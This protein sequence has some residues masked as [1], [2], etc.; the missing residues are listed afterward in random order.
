[1]S[2]A[3]LELEMA[4]WAVAEGRAT[5]EE[6]ALV[7]TDPARS[8]RVLTL[9]ASQTE[10]DLE[11]ARRRG[12]REG[13]LATVDLEEQL[14]MLARALGRLDGTRLP[15]EAIAEEPPAPLQLQASWSAGS[16]VVWAAGRG[17]EPADN[18]ELAD[19]LESIGGPALGWGQHPDVELP[20]GDRADALRIPVK[21]ALGWLV[22]VGAGLGA[23][24][25]V[26]PSVRW[27]GHVAT[28]A[29][30][31]VAMGAV[32]PTLRRKRRRDRPD[33]VRRAMGAGAPGQR[34][35]RSRSS[36]PCRRPWPPWPR[37]TPAPSRWPRSGPSSTPSCATPPPGS[38]CRPRRPTSRRP[39][40]SPRRSP[41]GW[42]APP[43][44]RPSEVANEVTGRLE[45]WA[46]PATRL[47]RP[48]LVVQ[49]EPPDRGDAW[50]LGVL[51]QTTSGALL[52]IE[53]AMGDTPEPRVMMDELA[54]LERVLPALRRPGGLRRG[55]VVL[56][57]QEAW[58][59]MTVTGASLQAAGFEVRAPALSRRKPKPHT[60][61]VHRCGPARTPWSAP[62][63]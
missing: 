51:G 46:R 10:S 29:V 45:R 26:G 32:V 7:D 23:D 30:R 40:P 42:T 18:E 33:R 49:L 55:Q 62:I 1:M 5:A 9:L 19:L 35:D 39:R 24:D 36:P 43:S 13:E 11:R 14:A 63:S 8:R 60:A 25:E 56:S 37:P 58:E 28:V 16:I 21:D 2:N 6:T 34:G 12:G 41:P 61:S 31:H 50:M 44:R 54:R 52:P 17:T 22:A 27:L 53:Q 57:Q 38:P 3:T 20:D 15:S 47:G 48:A 59:L 4:V